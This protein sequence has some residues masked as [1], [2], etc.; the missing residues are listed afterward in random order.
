MSN[1]EI[2]D[3]IDIC[4]VIILDIWLHSGAFFAAV[5]VFIEIAR[6]FMD[7][8]CTGVCDVTVVGYWMKVGL[9]KD[10]DNWIGFLQIG[11]ISRFHIVVCWFQDNLD[12]TKNNQDVNVDTE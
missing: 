8:F 9:M 3:I 6:V 11:C 10:R 12:K 2:N 4:S 1:G 7:A 5:L